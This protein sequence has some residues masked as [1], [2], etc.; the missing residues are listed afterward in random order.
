MAPPLSIHRPQLPEPHQR[1]SNASPPSGP[2]APATRN[3]STFLRRSVSGV[4]HLAAPAT[5]NA[6]DSEPE[7]E[8]AVTAYSGAFLTGDAAA[9]DLLSQRCRDR[10]D[11][12]AFLTTLDQAKELYGSP[13]T[14]LTYDAEVSGDLARVT[15]T[16]EASALNQDSEPLG[17]G[18]RR[19]AQRRLLTSSRLLEH[20]GSSTS[21][22]W[23]GR[24][25]A[26]QDQK[27][28]RQWAVFRPRSAV[29]DLR[30]AP[31]LGSCKAS[32]TPSERRHCR[33][34]RIEQRVLLPDPLGSGSWSDAEGRGGWSAHVAAAGA[35]LA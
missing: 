20:C 16:Y 9:Y 3:A 11:K 28:L 14:I 30:C 7:L 26:R 17:E 33:Q 25:A 21:P 2:P 27:W 31:R 8:A 23:Q 24:A 4:C 22:P 13:L 35:P 32:A 12:D 10:T 34:L 6:D 19:V 29:A 18:G 15:Y 5:S 1:P